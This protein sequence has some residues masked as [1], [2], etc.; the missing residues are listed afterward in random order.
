MVPKEKTKVNFSLLVDSALVEDFLGNPDCAIQI[1]NSGIAYDK[2]SF[3]DIKLL[4]IQ[5]LKVY[6][7]NGRFAEGLAEAEEMYKKY[8]DICY[9]LIQLLHLNGLESG[10]LFFKD[11][12]GNS[13]IGEYLCEGARL[14]MNP[15]SPIFDLNRA[16]KYLEKALHQTPQDWRYLDRT[17]APDDH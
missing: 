11:L 2:Y 9:L 7:R 16:E 12:P 17:P 15:F 8:P 4:N 1:L 6:I 3:K 10:N 5:K 14:A 13:R